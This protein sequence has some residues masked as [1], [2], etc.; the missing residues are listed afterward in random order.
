MDWIQFAHVNTLMNLRVLDMPAISLTFGSLSFHQQGH[1][2]V[3]LV[4]I[5]GLSVFQNIF[6]VPKE[7]GHNN[8][9]LQFLVVNMWP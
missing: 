5:S 4:H 7:T 1:F 3:E 8:N 2:F 6:H 9:P